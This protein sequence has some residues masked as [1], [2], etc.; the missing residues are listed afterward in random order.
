MLSFL[1]LVIP[2][3]VVVN[4]VDGKLAHSA[5]DSRNDS[6]S[7]KPNVDFNTTPMLLESSFISESDL[8]IRNETD[9]S[10][11]GISNL[12]SSSEVPVFNNSENFSL[13]ASRSGATEKQTCCSALPS[14]CNNEGHCVLDMTT[15]VKLC[16][17]VTGIRDAWCHEILNR[18]AQEVIETSTPDINELSPLPRSSK[19]TVAVGTP[20]ITNLPPFAVKTSK[21]T[22]AP[23]HLHPLTTNAHSP[24]NNATGMLKTGKTYNST[25]SR[26]S[27]NSR[28]HIFGVPGSNST[29]QLSTKET[30]RQRNV[31]AMNLTEQYRVPK[32]T[33]SRPRKTGFFDQTTPLTSSMTSDRSS[34]ESSVESLVHRTPSKTDIKIGASGI[35]NSDSLFVPSSELA[36][37]ADRDFNV[38]Q[39]FHSLTTIM[40]NEIVLPTSS[41][42]NDH[43]KSHPCAN[44]PGVCRL[45]FPSYELVCEDATENRCE[46][47][48]CGEHG[49]CIQSNVTNLVSCRCDGMYTGTFCEQVCDLDCGDNGKCSFVNDSATCV[50]G[51]NNTGEFCQFLKTTV[52]PDVRG[53][54]VYFHYY[55]L[56]CLLTYLCTWIF[57][58]LCTKLLIYIVFTYLRT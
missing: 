12:N 32:Q 31:N 5:H 55:L 34:G 21:I 53:Q 45:T 36:L 20:E 29:S 13:D 19:V 41:S 54:C 7:V 15:C 42:D 49:T 56:A 51:W 17:C 10:N 23:V 4:S 3:A 52:T 6:P 48:D 47:F 27:G 30:G 46:N 9:V 44:C 39:F 18:L 38:D 37:I 8:N 1:L 28:H 26:H 14:I 57:A 50:C 11:S 35:I 24:P 16:L 33:R 2:A 40:P 43:D 58:Y 25:S 22:A